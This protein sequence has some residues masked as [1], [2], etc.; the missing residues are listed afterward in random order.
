M[1]G[2]LVGP[3]LVVTAAPAQAYTPSTA[4]VAAYEARVIYQINVQRVKYARGKLAA[5]TCPD[6][7]SE[8]WGSYL[9][10]TGKFYHQSLTPILRGCAAT[11]ASENLARGYATADSTVA[12]WMAS[13]GHRANVL[14]GRVTRIGVAAVYS[15]GRWTVVADFTRS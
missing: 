14:D 5:G 11:R 6:K 10:R 2:L 4:T 13:S 3:G 8:T 12:A 15:G 9:A 7:Y 1:A